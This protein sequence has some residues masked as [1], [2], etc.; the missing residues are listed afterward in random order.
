MGEILLN[1]CLCINMVIE[2]CL[3][4]KMQIVHR[5]GNS[6]DALLELLCL[7]EVEMEITM[8]TMKIT[9]MMKMIT[10]TMMTIN[11]M[12]AVMMI[13]IITVLMFQS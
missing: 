11:M 4:K 5:H 1:F 6:P 12:M 3:L 7:V 2:H 10:V 13:I 8:M 9:M